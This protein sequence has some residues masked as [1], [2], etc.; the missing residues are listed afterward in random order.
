MGGLAGGCHF[1][2]GFCRWVVGVRPGWEELVSTLSVV[3]G[4]GTGPLLPTVSVS[5]GPPLELRRQ[6]PQGA[7]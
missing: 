1:K 5:F 7:S 3:G 4:Q 6:E 2:G